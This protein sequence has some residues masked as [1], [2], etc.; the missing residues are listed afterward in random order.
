MIYDELQVQ[1]DVSM[2]YKV[3]NMYYE[4]IYGVEIRHDNS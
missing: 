4:S 2:Y 1:A 3:Q